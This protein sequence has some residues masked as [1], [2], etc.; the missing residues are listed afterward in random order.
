MPKKEE[1]PDTETSLFASMN[2]CIKFRYTITYGV[3][4]L[5]QSFRLHDRPFRKKDTESQVV[6]NFVDKW[7]VR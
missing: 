1:L 6:S 4:T 2:F 7:L 5:N 3:A